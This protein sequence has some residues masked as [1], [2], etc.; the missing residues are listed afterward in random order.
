MTPNLFQRKRSLSR[1]AL[2]WPGSDPKHPT[3]IVLTTNPREIKSPNV[4][5]TEKAQQQQRNIGDSMQNYAAELRKIETSLFHTPSGSQLL[6]AQSRQRE[7]LSLL[8]TYLDSFRLQPRCY[9]SNVVMKCFMELAQSQTHEELAWGFCSLIPDTKLVLTRVMG[10]F[11]ANQ[12]M[13]RPDITIRFL[14]MLKHHQWTTTILRNRAIDF[15]ETMLIHA[16]RKKCSVVIDVLLNRLIPLIPQDDIRAAFPMTLL[17]LVENEDIPMLRRFQIFL[18]HC[19]PSKQIQALNG[20]AFLHAV[21]SRRASTM[22]YFLLEEPHTVSQSY[23]EIAF[24]WLASC[25]SKEIKNLH[26]HQAMLKFVQEHREKVAAPISN[27]LTDGIAPIAGEMLLRY[28]AEAC[29]FASEK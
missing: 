13:R 3:Q 19:I 20:M 9:D 21:Q 23:L 8:R 4:C 14:E 29:F 18:K 24:Q 27:S 11:M 1:D 25:Q 28:H 10:D 2:L 6:L 26:E 7:L 5:N 16:F 17:N 12:M 15:Y 22:R